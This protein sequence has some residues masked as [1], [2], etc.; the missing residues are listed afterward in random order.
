[1]CGFW[2]LI[3]NFKFNWIQVFE[4]SVF[5]QNFTSLVLLLR[6]ICTIILFLPFL[7]YLIFT[8]CCWCTAQKTCSSGPQ[9][10]S[11]VK[12]LNIFLVNTNSL[13]LMRFI[14]Y[15]NFIVHR[16]SLISFISIG[17]LFELSMDFTLLSIFL[18]YFSGRG[19]EPVYKIVKWWLFFL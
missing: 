9:F 13:K 1:M 17:G 18:Y 19:G 7:F 5:M 11:L 10:N 14:F 6:K 4:F 8:F 12:E 3:Q 2:K 15:L 16:D